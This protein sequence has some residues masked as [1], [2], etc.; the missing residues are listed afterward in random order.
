MM[1]TIKIGSLLA[2]LAL[3]S[4][5][6]DDGGDDDTSETTDMTPDSDGTP[7]TGCAAYCAQITMNC[8][9]DNA[10][11]ES[12]A[13]CVSYCEEASWPEGEEGAM[14]GNTLACRIYHSGAPAMG[15]PQIHC[16]HGGPTGDTVC[17]TV[18]F[19]VNVAADYTRVD[20]AGVPGV[21]KFLVSTNEASAYNDSSPDSTGSANAFTSSIAALHTALDTS[22]AGLGYTTCNGNNCQQQDYQTGSTVRS[23]FQPTDRLTVTPSMP[24]GFPNGRSPSDQAM[25]IMLA[26]V[27]LD[28]EGGTCGTG[29]NP[30]ACTFR[31]FAEPVA[32]S[33]NP[34]ANDVAFS[35]SFPY[36]APAHP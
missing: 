23:L 17:G 36:L 29:P 33:L 5:C 14:S 1:H 10:Q 28:L 34:P 15:A 4:A 32:T 2:A 27:L 12:E 18:D 24:Q 35:T 9:G 30:P 22:L 20:A 19:R 8:A 7:V 31:S 26:L 25:N 16:G 6:G 3:A 11:Y 13:D 21:S